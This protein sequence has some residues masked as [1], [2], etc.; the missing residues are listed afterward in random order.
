MKTWQDSRL[1]IFLAIFAFAITGAL[2]IGQIYDFAD[3]QLMQFLASA[4]VIL[5]I[6]L[7][8]ARLASRPAKPGLRP[9]EV[10][11]E[12]A[13]VR[14]A[15]TVKWFNADKGFGFIIRENGEDLFVHFRAISDGHSSRLTEGQ[16]VEYQIG[17]G[18]KGPQAEE[19]VI[20]D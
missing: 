6:A 9:K 13:P 1:T 4:A 3:Q 17:Q 12:H 20:L 18:R 5:V 14:E 7:L 11:V 16:T 19:V 2:A 15:G 8:S 10:A